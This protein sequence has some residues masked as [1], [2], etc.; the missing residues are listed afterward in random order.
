MSEEFLLGKNQFS[1]FV[2]P[3]IAFYLLLSVSAGTSV[4]TNN[5]PVDIST[6]Q[7][8]NITKNLFDRHSCQSIFVITLDG[9]NL[10]LDPFFRQIPSTVAISVTAWR[11]ILNLNR[12]R[13]NLNFKVSLLVMVMDAALEVS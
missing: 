7:A 11:T 6:I 4:L 9:T 13:M 8:L 5:R 1:H 12:N 2:S 3:M 10:D